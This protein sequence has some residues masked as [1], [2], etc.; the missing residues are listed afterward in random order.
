MEQLTE[1]QRVRLTAKGKRW[2][3]GD[4]A[5]EHVLA[6]IAEH[7]PGQPYGNDYKL[8]FDDPAIGGLFPWADKRDIEPWPPGAPAASEPA[9]TTERR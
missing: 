1:R 6:T 8:K 5:P 3:C 2:F 7:K 9:P 4:G